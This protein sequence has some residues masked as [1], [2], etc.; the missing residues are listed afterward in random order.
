MMTELD[1]KFAA[2]ARSTAGEVP[3]REEE[4]LYSRTD[5]KGKISAIGGAMARAT[6][7][8]AKDLLGESFASIR[9]PDTPRAVFHIL[10]DRLGAG[11]P[12]AVYLKNK[13]NRG[14]V[15][16]TLLLA[17]PVDGG[18]VGIQIKPGTALLS[19]IGPIYK[20][21]LAQEKAGEL[22]PKQSA[23]FLVSELQD[24]GYVDY[25]AFQS[26]AL[27][28]ECEARATAMR[29][30]LGSAQKRLI[31]MSR[32]IG[33]VQGE[34]SEMTEAFNDIRTVPMNMRIIASRLENAGGPISAISV[35]YSQMLDEMSSWVQTFVK[36]EGCVFARIRH[37]IHSAQFSGF[38][39]AILEEAKTLMA[40]DAGLGA[41]ID[42][43]E[44]QIATLR[45]AFRAQTV[46]ALSEVEVEAARFG[47][48]V[49]DMKRYVTGLSSTR[50]MCKIES[51]A[52]SDRG[53]ALVG[54]V[55]QLD[56]CQTE[57][58]KR[59]GRIVELNALVE[60]NTS[61]LLASY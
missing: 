41:G 31:A 58:E 38:I 13:D 17:A 55:E 46:D 47:R 23:D 33:D 6:G 49:Q 44:A 30:V 53:T 29:T 32:G 16:W 48:S 45:D 51:A 1:P 42:G 5:R 18:H 24:L 22:S 2:E 7:R 37:R 36:G 57:I 28:A 54:I 40:E 34:T 4:F 20:E 27:A 21:C 25:H 43:D 3:L 39:A 14:R 8:D 11:K 50:M 61:M 12:A 56:L 9:H 19:Q 52:L 60:T 35:N 59:L 26:D 10:W 15:F